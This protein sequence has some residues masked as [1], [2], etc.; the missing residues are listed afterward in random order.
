MVTYL[1]HLPPFWFPC[2]LHLTDVSQFAP[3]VSSLTT[4]DVS[5]RGRER[6]AHARCSWCSHPT[7]YT[8]GRELAAPQRRLLCVLWKRFLVKAYITSFGWYTRWKR[9]T[10]VADICPPVTFE[11][12]GRG[13]PQGTTSFSDTSTS[14]LGSKSTVTAFLSMISQFSSCNRLWN[15]ISTS[16]WLR[17]FVTQFMD[18]SFLPKEQPFE[19]FTSTC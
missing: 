14:Y 17:P 10:K 19:A 1:L 7:T 4:K 2:L 13:L 15:E 11:R 18:V 8:S 16:Q 5:A 9:S 6:L 12:T 3:G